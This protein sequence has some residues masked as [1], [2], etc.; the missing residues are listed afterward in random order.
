MKLFGIV[1]DTPPTC[2]E[3]VPVSPVVSEDGKIIDYNYAVGV[4]CRGGGDCVV[5]RLVVLGATVPLTRRVEECVARRGTPYSEPTVNS[6]AHPGKEY[7]LRVFAQLNSPEP[8]QGVTCA[9]PNP[10]QA[11]ETRPNINPLPTPPANT[12][13]PQPAP[14]ARRP[15]EVQPDI[16][17]AP[18]PA[19]DHSSVGAWRP[20]AHP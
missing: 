13:N 6:T 9:S 3:M 18:V 10:E 7:P 8:R 12:A 4:A 14:W 17:P 1:R 5:R 20:Q 11:T 15:A 2:N 16:G 19:T